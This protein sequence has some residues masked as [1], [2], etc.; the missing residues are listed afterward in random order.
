[1]TSC[2]STQARVFGLLCEGLLWALRYHTA[3]RVAREPDQGQ[4]IIAEKGVDGFSLTEKHRYLI[5]RKHFAHTANSA[6][7]KD[8]GNFLAKAMA[9][10]CSRYLLITSLSQAKP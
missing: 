6:K 4:D 10:K 1:L 9:H 2:R 3:N 5:E 7:E 8:I